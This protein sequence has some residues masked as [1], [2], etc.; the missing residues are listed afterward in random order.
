MH[1]QCKSNLD[2]SQ[3]S[4][5]IFYLRITFQC[6]SR[7]LLFHLKIFGHFRFAP[8]QIILER[9]IKYLNWVTKPNI[10]YEPLAWDSAEKLE[11]RLLGWQNA[12]NENSCWSDEFVK[13]D[14][15]WE[16]RNVEDVELKKGLNCIKKEPIKLFT[17]W[18]IQV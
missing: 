5:Q 15:F 11:L 17:F 7:T 16:Q 13:L 14:W 8:C 12:N 2:N 18:N 9:K 4:L 10:W 1:N 6:L 3:S